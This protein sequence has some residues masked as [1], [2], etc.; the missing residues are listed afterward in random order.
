MDAH[1]CY[2]YGEWWNDRIDRALSAGTPV[3][4]EQDLAWYTDRKSG[5]SWSVVTHGDPITGREPTIE[6]YFFDRVRPVVEQ[7]LRADDHRSW[8]LITLN[9]DFKDDNPDHLAAIRVLL[10]KYRSWI[11][12]APKGNSSDTVQPLVVR[13]ILVLTG[14]SDAQQ[15]IFYD[16]LG[17][18]DPVLAFG[19]VHT[20]DKHYHAA[21]E[22]I[23]SE[24]ATNYRRW[25]N[26]PWR[27][28]ESGG[29]QHAGD[30]TPDKM[31][32][33]RALVERA[34]SNGL[35]IRFYTLDGA[36][37]D[38]LSCHGWFH[39]YNFGD[40]AAARKR[41]QAAIAVGVDYIASDQYELLGAEIQQSSRK[42]NTSRSQ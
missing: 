30:W 37:E 34:H 4:I 11:T 7:A 12:E 23:D 25:W 33:L 31:R 19:A 35:W 38:E 32:R 13:P 40:L 29:Q 17:P 9:L 36:D 41:W 1:N 28:V 5:R 24:K 2:P 26:N 3:A 18:D 8:P 39:T 6:H 15:A 27:V 21:P 20:V 42:G 16:H 14:E 22:E 10:L